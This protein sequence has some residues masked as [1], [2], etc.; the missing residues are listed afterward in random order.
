MVAIRHI[1]FLLALLAAPA[2]CPPESTASA[3]GILFAQ[4]ASEALT[5]EFPD[6][7]ISYL[8]FDAG[9][10]RLIASRWERP[11]IPIPLGSLLKPFAALAYGE[12]HN[13]RYPSHHC[14]GTATGCWRPAG[15]GEVDLVS[16][17]AH[18]CNSYF[19]M[20]T[21]DLSS[22]DILPV[23][24]RFGIDPPDNDTQA[25]ALAGLG[26]RWKISPLHMALAYLELVHRR[27]EPAINQIADGMEQSA[28]QGTGAE[29]DRLLT[30]PNALVKTGTAECMHRR[31]A[32]GDGF[33]IALV[34]ADDP[35]LLLMVRVHGVPG[36]EAAKTA[37]QMLRRVG[38]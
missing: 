12:R 35:K 31:H 14:R 20:L 24:A 37:G 16:A 11:D 34:P 28:R 21:S 30:A 33:T 3:P 27:Y 36:A 22:T 19:R 4:A 23:A 5:R 38:N 1:P 29:V 17:I 10:G 2:G 15:H 18:S 32:P 6:P 25:A 7:N 9:T 13:F 26:S 8:L